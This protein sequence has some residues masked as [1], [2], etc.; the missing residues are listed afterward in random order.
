MPTKTRNKYRMHQNWPKK[1]EEVDNYCPKHLVS[2]GAGFVALGY[3][4]YLV[5]L[6]ARWYRHHIRWLGDRIPI[7]CRYTTM[8][9]II[10]AGMA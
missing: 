9:V 6:M 3:S 8:E 2:R 1:K 5:L 7:R 10:N 4:M